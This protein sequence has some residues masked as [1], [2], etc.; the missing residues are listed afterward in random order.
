MSRDPGYSR[1]GANGA[2]TNGNASY[3]SNG[4]YGSYGASTDDYAARPSGESRR[5]PGGYGGLGGGDDESRSP[6]RPST[7]RQR[8]PGAYGGVSP[9]ED[10]YPS[11][12]SGESARERRPGGY[13]G[14]QPRNREPNRDGSREDPQ[15]RNQER[16]QD[17]PQVTRPTSIERMP[18]RP[19][20]GGRY[21]NVPAQSRNRPGAQQNYGP[22]SQRIEEVIK[23]I[24]DNWDFMTGD[25]CVPIEVALKLMDSSSL[26]LADQSDQFR[27]SHQELQQALKTI[28]NEHHQGFNSSIG[29]FHQ[30]QT[31]LQTSQH[32]VRNLKT[33]LT[34]AK[35]QLS[36]TK[37]ELREFATASQNYDEMIQMLNTIEQL[38]LIPEKLE[39]RIS[40]KRF[41]T[42]V[43]VLQDALRLIRKSEMENIGALSDLRTY[44]SNQE[45]SLTDILIE[46]L[47]SHLYLKSPYCEERWKEY[48]HNQF[49]GDVSERAQAD[50]RGR[51]L[52]YFLEGLDVT[53]PVRILLCSL[54]VPNS[55]R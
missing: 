31:S 10:N 20:S 1:A 13:G 25:Q 38:Q 3:N 43:D 9:A 17:A 33:S 24:Q 39:A 44:L 8:R 2:Y 6:S 11:R 45:V 41:L 4:T 26:G 40:E 46:E 23:Y 54:H 53:E 47:H 48:T 14:F 12:P 18:V 37:P 5:R 55:Y 52:Y 34:S 19:R 27:Q 49:K 21:G 35:S 15:E 7:D 16:S 22:G 51:L 36:T 50:V 42:A 32:R 30:I 28:V 29:T